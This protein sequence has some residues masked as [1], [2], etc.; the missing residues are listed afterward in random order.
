MSETGDFLP[1]LPLRCSREKPSSTY[2]RFGLFSDNLSS[3]MD[4]EVCW[5]QPEFVSMFQVQIIQTN[6]TISKYLSLN[7][8]YLACKKVAVHIFDTEASTIFCV[9]NKHCQCQITQF[10]HISTIGVKSPACARYKNLQFNLNSTL[11]SGAK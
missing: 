4:T 9:I 11:C 5:I 2:R 8:Q 6:F 7:L 1:S 3:L 10:L